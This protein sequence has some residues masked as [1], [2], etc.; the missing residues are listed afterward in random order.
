[1]TDVHDLTGER[2]S[3]IER[4]APQARSYGPGSLPTCLS[5]RLDESDPAPW[6]SPWP[7]EGPGAGLSHHRLCDVV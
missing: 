4:M 1:L 3:E 6:P 5:G 7:L 2:F